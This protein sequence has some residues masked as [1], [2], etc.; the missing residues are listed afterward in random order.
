M[1]EFS[2]NDAKSPIRRLDRSNYDFFTRSLFS[3]TY[4]SPKRRLEGYWQQSVVENLRQIMD[5][6]NQDSISKG[7]LIDYKDTLYAVLY[8]LHFTFLNFT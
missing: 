7:R 8:S 5:K 1:S 2:L 4:I 3:S 6:I